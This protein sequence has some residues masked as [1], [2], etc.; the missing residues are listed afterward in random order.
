MENSLT[1]LMARQLLR[2]KL[3][4]DS[5]AAQQGLIQLYKFYCREERCAECDVGSVVFRS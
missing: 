4:L 2:G 5:V 1:R 3:R